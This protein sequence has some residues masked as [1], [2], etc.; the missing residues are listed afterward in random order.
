MPNT[1][2]A[3]VAII[4]VDPGKPMGITADPEGDSST[5][6]I[7]RWNEPAAPN[8]PIAFYNVTLGDLSPIKSKY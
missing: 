4:Y 7:I 8:G 1:Q 6:A 3:S 5:V 2:I